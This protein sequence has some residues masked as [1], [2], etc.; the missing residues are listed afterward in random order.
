MA[1]KLQ[2]QVI[3]ATTVVVWGALLLIQGVTLKASY[4]RPYSLVVGILILLQVVFDRWLWRVPAVAR[5][6]RCPVL[7]GTWK[8]Q[9]R[10]TWEDSKTGQRIEPIDV[11]L[12]VRQ[13]YSTVSIRLMTAESSSRSARGLT[14]D[15]TR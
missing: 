9:L 15:A 11:F 6:L 2:T 13:T 1:G 7:R 10:S 14:S 12:V 8:G 3:L 5:V 4:L